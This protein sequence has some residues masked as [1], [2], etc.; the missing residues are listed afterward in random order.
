MTAA[1]IREEDRV[2]ELPN[3]MLTKRRDLRGLGDLV[4][5]VRGPTEQRLHPRERP[6]RVDHLERNGH[7]GEDL[8]ADRSSVRP[9]TKLDEVLKDHLEEVHSVAVVGTLA[10]G[11]L[12][13]EPN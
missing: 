8:L 3:A 13:T 9:S 11:D 12:Q 6:V 4:L 5:G 1:R 2:L 10:P 7:P